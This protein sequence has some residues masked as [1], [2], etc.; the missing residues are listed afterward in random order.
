MMCAVLDTTFETFGEEDFEDRI[1]RAFS[2]SLETQSYLPLVKQEL[3]YKIQYERLTR[4][5]PELILEEEPPKNYEVRYEYK[6]SQINKHFPIY[7]IIILYGQRKQ[8]TIGV[9]QL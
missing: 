2:E 4:G 9:L 3:Q 7:I 6:C 5:E 8:S 1:H